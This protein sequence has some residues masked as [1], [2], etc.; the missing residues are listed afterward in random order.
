MI[1]LGIGRLLNAQVA[2]ARFVGILLIG[3]GTI[4]FL[5]NVGL[6][7][8]RTHDGS[9]PLSLLLIA[10]GV[11]MLLRVLDAGAWGRP[12]FGFARRAIGGDLQN[13]MQD[14]AIFG[15]VKRRVDAVDFQGGGAISLF[16]NVD[17]DLRR[18]LISPT[19]SPVTLEATAI[20]GS[21]KLRVADGWKVT[22]HGVGILGSYEDKTIPP[23]TGDDAPVL[24][25]T[26]YSIF[27][28]V[29][30]ED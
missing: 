16:G 2:G 17:L 6:I 15:S 29:E 21:I 4:F 9:W 10:F 24:I 7:H 19:R 13:T 20:F 30:I 22:V 27:G 3:F 12:A 14:C 8:I 28:S 23:N 5:H 11:A 18:A 25:I 26:G 1:A